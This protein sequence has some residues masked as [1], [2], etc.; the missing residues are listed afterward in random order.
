MKQEQLEQLLLK[1]SVKEKVGQLTQFAGAFYMKHDDG[2]PVTGRI[3]FPVEDDMLDV[4]GSVLGIAGFEK[5]KAIQENHLHRS[6]LG[7]PLLFMADVINGFQ[8]I[9]PIPLGLGATWEPSL[10]EKLQAV[11]SK[12]ASS[13]GLHVSFA[14]MADLV[15]DPRWGRVMESTGED[16]YLNER[17]AAATVSGLQGRSETISNDHIGACVKHFAA[18]GLSEGGR[19][20]NTVDLSERE[21]REMHMPAYKAALQAG[22][23][24]VMTAFN[25]VNGMPASGNAPLLRGMLRDELDF[26]GVVISDFDAVEELVAHGVAENESVAA[27]KALQAGVDIDMM[28]LSYARSLSSLVEQN[29][30]DASLLDEAVLRVLEL[31]NELGLF[32]DPYRGM[33]VTNEQAV[34]NAAEHRKLACEVAEKS[35][36][37]LKNQNVLPLER[38]RSIALVGPYADN[39]D[40]LGEWSIFG[41]MEETK[42]LKDR[43]PDARYAQGSALYHREETLLLEALDVMAQA[44]VIVLAL[45]EGRDRSGEARSRA[46]ITLAPCQIELLKKAHETGKPVVVTLFNARPIDLTDVE[47]YADAILECWH[48]GSEGAQAVVNVLFGKTNPSGK[49]TMS[50]PR[51]TGQIPV[52]YNAYK[53]GRP[54]PEGSEERFYSRYIDIPNEPLYPFGFGLSYAAFTYSNRRIS[55]SELNP[56]STLIVSVDVTN[57]SLVAGEEVVQLYIQ[58]VVGEVVRPVKELKGFEKISLLPNETK[59]VSFEIDS[60]MLRYH[61]SDL[62]YASDPGLFHVWMDG[63]SVCEDEGKLTFTFHTS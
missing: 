51:A 38:N 31:K 56:S 20:Y 35:M 7:I 48:P 13:A 30:I 37:L 60:E 62:S 42:T 3:E 19:D 2:T 25:T 58:D 61:H 8:T 9:F 12:E 29:L 10:I 21:L 46:S 41:N 17:F 44:D 43:L 55:Q 16:P 27:Q 50:F 1:M 6:R 53:T 18:Y 5:V 40:L 14:P 33:S 59:T 36:V 4:S 57:T 26:E 54:L 49:L 22:A 39:P 34:L 23:K 45:G 24:L 52:Y 28:S 32:E 47:P 63:S 11:A 15:R